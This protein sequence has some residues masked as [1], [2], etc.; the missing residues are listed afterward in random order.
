VLL[1]ENA[2]KLA[3][4]ARLFTDQEGAA[5]ARKGVLLVE[6]PGSR[7]EESAKYTGCKLR[8]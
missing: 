7:S 1:Q 8:Y 3:Y 4:L 2:E 6:R 5:V